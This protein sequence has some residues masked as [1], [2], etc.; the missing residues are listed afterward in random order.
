MGGGW[1]ASDSLG[2]RLLGSGTSEVDFG[3]REG[4]LIQLNASRAIL[5]LVD[6]SKWHG[7]GSTAGPLLVMRTSKNSKPRKRRLWNLMPDEK[8]GGKK[9][10]ERGEVMR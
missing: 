3:R 4:C 10:I 8:V 2:L 7:R 6:E 1:E 5:G 9:E